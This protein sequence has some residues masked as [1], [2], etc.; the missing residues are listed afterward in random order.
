MEG[1]TAE[2]ERVDP[3]PIVTALGQRTRDKGLYT[4]H[5][6]GDSSACLTH[7]PGDCVI[8]F[9]GPPAPGAG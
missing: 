8:V 7:P 5:W 1:P 6:I 2:L 3:P 4:A 9:S